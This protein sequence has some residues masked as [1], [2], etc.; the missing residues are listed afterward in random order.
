MFVRTLLLL[1]LTV[2][3]FGL[4]PTRLVAEDPSPCC[5]A[6]VE[7]VSCCGEVV[8]EPACDNDATATGPCCCAV[9]EPVDPAPPEDPATAPSSTPSRERLPLATPTDERLS[10][11]EASANT[12]RDIRIESPPRPKRLD[13]RSLL[14]VWVV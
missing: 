8:L 11:I 12:A 9:P 2:Q 14:C 5:C 10:A 7:T 6:P 4:A 3:A 1:A 13:A